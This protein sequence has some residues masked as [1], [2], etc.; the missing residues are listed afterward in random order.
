ME[1]LIERGEDLFGLRSEA[2]RLLREV[3]KEIDVPEGDGSAID[4]I[5]A[6]VQ[7]GNAPGSLV[8]VDAIVLGLLA[9]MDVDVS[10]VD[11][12]MQEA[13]IRAQD[14]GKDMQLIARQTRWRTR[15]VEE[16]SLIHI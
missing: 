11:G 7:Q 8:D 4:R 10:D 9:R 12:D 2:A 16:L 13:V 5:V 15:Q 3:R 6:H 14:A 1:A